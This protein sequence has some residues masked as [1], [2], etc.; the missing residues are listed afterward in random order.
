[1]RHNLQVERIDKFI[2]R[3]LLWKIG[4]VTQ[5]EQRDS[6]Q[7]RLFEQGVKFLLCYR[8][9]LLI[10]SV[11]DVAWRLVSLLGRLMTLVFDVH[12]S[13][14]PTTVPLPH[15]SKPWLTPKVPAGPR[16][17]QISDAA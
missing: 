1:M 16:L 2:D 15:G 6:I 17:V 5:D 12:D 7:D 9:S 10:R 14:D 13:V 8:K 11:Y 4:L 3:K